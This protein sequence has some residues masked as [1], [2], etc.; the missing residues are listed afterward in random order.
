[1]GTRNVWARAAAAAATNKI[2][3]LGQ[4]GEVGK[5]RAGGLITMAAETVAAHIAAHEE[6]EKSAISKALRYIIP[7]MMLCYFVAFLDR[8]NGVDL[9]DQSLRF[10]WRESKRRAGNSPVSSSQR[11]SSFVSPI[12][13]SWWSFIRENSSN[14][15]L[16]LYRSPNQAIKLLI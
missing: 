8:T 15:R 9:L 10:R 12:S 1:M 16:R 13:L 14:S 6:I 5:H 2:D 7:F 11:R 4:L 3:T